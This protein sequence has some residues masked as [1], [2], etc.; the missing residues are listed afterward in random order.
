MT[1]APL[2]P[3]QQRPVCGVSKAIV[4]ETMKGET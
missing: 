2:T 3:G 4:T 1:R